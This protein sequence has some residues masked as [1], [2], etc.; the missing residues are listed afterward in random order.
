MPTLIPNAAAALVTATTG[1]CSIPSGVPTLLTFS[2]WTQFRVPTGK[3]SEHPRGMPLVTRMQV[4]QASRRRNQW[5]HR[6]KISVEAAHHA[7]APTSPS[8]VPMVARGCCLLEGE[9]YRTVA[10]TSPSA[11]IPSM[12]KYPHP[13]KPFAP[14][15]VCD[16]IGVVAEFT[17][18]VA[19]QARLQ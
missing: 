12:L 5:H 2:G 17:V 7:V 9:E 8:A 16:V 11:S 3:K 1:R 15:V 10:P 18:R 14:A 19:R 13:R 4:L 6:V